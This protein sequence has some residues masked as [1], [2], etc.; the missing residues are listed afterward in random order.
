MKAYFEARW[1]SGKHVIKV[2]NPFTGTAFDEVPL[3]G[4]VELEKA[5]SSLT[6]GSRDIASLSREDLNQI[7]VNFHRILTLHA[8]EVSSLI[9]REQ[10]KPIQEAR[11]EVNAALGSAESLALNPSLSG[12]VIQPLGIEAKFAERCGYTLRHPH[13]IVGIIGANP[14]P[15]ILP[16]VNT[17][18]ALAAGNAVILKPSQHTSLVALRIVAM[19]LKAGVPPNA[20]ACVTG[21]GKKIGT[22]L[23]SHPA[24][25]HV[26][27]SGNLSTIRKIRKHMGF[28]TS[29]LQW[30]CVA[31]CVVG[32]SADIETV[33]NEILR[34]AF[35]CSGQAAFTPTWIACFEQK[36]DELRD[37]LAES[38]NRLSIGD[39]MLESTLIGPLTERKKVERLENRLANETALGAEIVTGGKRDHQLFQPMLL[40]QCHLEKT[41]FSRQEIAAPI[42]GLTSIR[43]AEDATSVLAGQRHHVLTL[44]SN[45]LDWASRR[46][47]RMPFN[48]VHIN[49]IPTWRDGLICLPGNPIRTGR[50]SAEDR[51]SDMSHV[52]DVIFH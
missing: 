45:D 2:Y 17:L 34:V 7:F 36:H 26:I 49:G 20:I 32:K 11:R 44:F 39:P 47:V 31:S 30:G 1:Q 18:Y 13:G 27:A 37:A 5:I 12:S 52:R 6:K 3:C 9:T 14:Q 21:S 51:I 10:G 38:M 16:L 43:K 35:E 8:E 23:I 28:V 42:I 19:L 15:L 29:Q 50:R 46:A 40:D 41:Q 4:P 24:I 22:A 48:N 33:C 25:N